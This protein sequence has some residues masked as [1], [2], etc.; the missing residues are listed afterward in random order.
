MI[1]SGYTHFANTAM[2]TPCG[3][4]EVTS[5]ACLVWT[6][7]HMVIW[8]F[9]YLLLVVLPSNSRRFR[10]GASIN[11]NIRSNTKYH[12]KNM[13]E[14]AHAGPGRRYKQDFGAQKNRNE[15]NLSFVRYSSM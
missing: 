14:R 2:L 10:S 5:S 6:K 1:M 13:M 15:K 3:L 7:E 4:G 8:I 11:C 12:N 9:P